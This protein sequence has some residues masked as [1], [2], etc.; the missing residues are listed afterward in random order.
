MTLKGQFLLLPV[1]ITAA[2]GQA[3]TTVD[4]DSNLK[5]LILSFLA[6]FNTTYEL[7]Y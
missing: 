2:I 3:L 4:L 6:T 5:T 7:N 1:F